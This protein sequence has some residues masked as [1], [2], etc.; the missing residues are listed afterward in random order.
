M[1]EYALRR[2]REQHQRKKG[3]TMRTIITQLLGILAITQIGIAG[4]QRHPQ[5]PCPRGSR[6]TTI[7]TTTTTTASGQ[8]NGGVSAGIGSAGVAG[9]GSQTQQRVETYRVCRPMSP[10]PT[11]NPAVPTKTPKR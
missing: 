1:K 9:G 10:T 6:E 2:E 8:V 4:D 7:Q 3:K 5:D 11:P